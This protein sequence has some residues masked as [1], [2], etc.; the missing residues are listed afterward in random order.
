MTEQKAVELASPGKIEISDDVIKTIAGHAASKVAGIFGL[1]GG[2]IEGAK[3]AV[4]GRKDFSAGVE[5]KRDPSGVISLDMHIVVEFGVKI[6]EVASAVQSAT[7]LQVEAITGRS[8]GAVNINV[9][10]IKF[11]EEQLA[12]IQQ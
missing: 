9:A 5:V 7:K 8:V 12:P 10:D 11:T 1:K 2:F 4:T 3:Q 6:A